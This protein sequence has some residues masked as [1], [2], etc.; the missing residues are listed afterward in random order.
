VI[1]L[2]L[3]SELRAVA[4]GLIAGSLT[5]LP[6]AHALTHTLFEVDA[7]DPWTFNVAAVALA[8]VATLAPYVP[9]R[10]A[11]AMDAAAALRTL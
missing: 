2:V 6:V 3:G 9:A 8:A 7:F 5:A 11:L 10:R 4:A 1:R